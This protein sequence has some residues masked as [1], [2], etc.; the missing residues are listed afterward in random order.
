[1]QS[2]ISSLYPL[3]RFF[4]NYKPAKYK[5]QQFSSDSKV[6][7]SPVSHSFHP[8]LTVYPCCCHWKIPLSHSTFFSA[9]HSSPTNFR[10]IKNT[11]CDVF[12][13]LNLRPPASINTPG[14]GIISILPFHRLLKKNKIAIIYNKCEYV[15]IVFQSASLFAV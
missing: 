10:A 11:S 1:M 12:L 2:Q 15:S 9:H 5:S 13:P 3:V 6:P 8:D 14:V 7:S 4:S